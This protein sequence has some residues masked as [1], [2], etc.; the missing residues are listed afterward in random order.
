MSPISLLRFR[1]ASATGR[2][3]SPLTQYAQAKLFKKNFRAPR[4]GIKTFPGNT[5][6]ET[7]KYKDFLYR[8]GY[9][10]IQKVA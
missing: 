2:I 4:Q 1:V 3:I 7:Q 8:N 9:F 10:L 5:T 6:Y